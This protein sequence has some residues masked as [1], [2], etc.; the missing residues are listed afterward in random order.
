M[1]I[2]TRSDHHPATHRN[3]NP[4]GANWEDQTWHLDMVPL[5]KPKLGKAAA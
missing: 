3:A 2:G 5:T 4:R 1:T